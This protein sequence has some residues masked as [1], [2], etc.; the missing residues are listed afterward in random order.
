MGPS[1]KHQGT[2]RCGL[3]S[4]C[5]DILPQAYNRFYTPE[6]TPLI[7]EL[8]EAREVQSTAK[9]NFFRHLLAEFDKDRREWLGAVK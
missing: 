3:T 5:T 8:Q 4:L 9:R 7:R 6:S 2:P 1:D